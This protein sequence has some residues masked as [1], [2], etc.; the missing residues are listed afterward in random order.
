MCTK[1][2]CHQPKSIKRLS[3]FK[4]EAI[5]I[6]IATDGTRLVCPCAAAKSLQ[7]SNYKAMTA[8]KEGKGVGTGPGFGTWKPKP[9]GTLAFLT[10]NGVSADKLSCRHAPK[11]TCHFARKEGG[12]GFKHPPDADLATLECKRRNCEDNKKGNCL[13]KHNKN[14]KTLDFGSSSKD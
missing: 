9:N 1:G 3:G 7:S 5:P 10:G 4:R 14:P 13:Y 11:G 2:N 8:R 6:E 12:C